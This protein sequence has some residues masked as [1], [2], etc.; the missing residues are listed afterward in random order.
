MGIIEQ[1]LFVLFLGNSPNLWTLL[2]LWLIKVKQKSKIQVFVIAK[3][4]IFLH[5]MLFWIYTCGKKSSYKCNDLMT[6]I[7]HEILQN[8]GYTN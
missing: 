7:H 5:L 2:N 1:K 4:R 3:C 8:F 6:A